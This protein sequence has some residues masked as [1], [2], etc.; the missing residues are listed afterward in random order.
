MNWREFEELVGEAYRRQ[1][2]AVEENQG[3]GPDEG[4]DLVL[5]KG[6]DLVLVQCKHW[7]AVKVDVKIVREL[8]GV[9]AAKEAPHGVV[10]TSGMITQDARNFATDKPIDLV[11]GHLLLEL[12]GTVQ[13]PQESTGKQPREIVSAMWKRIGPPDSSPGIGGR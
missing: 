11:D 7:R 3:A 4:I 5:T 6:G 2:Y 9:M 13:K 10:I 12:I 1:G 8:Y